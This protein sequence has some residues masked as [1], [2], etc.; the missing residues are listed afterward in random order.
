LTNNNVSQGDL[1]LKIQSI[2][3]Y[4]RINSFYKNN[5]DTFNQNINSKIENIDK[6][7]RRNYLNQKY[8]FLN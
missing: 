7:F 6:A 2:N 8:Y 1:Q 5:V 4:N 3:N